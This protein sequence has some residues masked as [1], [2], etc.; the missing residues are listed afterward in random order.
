MIGAAAVHGPSAY[1]YLTR[2][3]GIVALILLSAVVV[4]GVLSSIRASGGPGLPRFAIGALHRDISLL[5]V[6][7]IVIHVVTTVLDGFAPIT[8][9]DAVIPF[10]SAYRPLWLGLGA[11]AFDL[12]LALVVTSLLRRRIGLGAWRAV[13]WFA[14]VSWPVAVLHGLGTGSDSGSV[15]A[16]AIVGACVAAVVAAV[17][18][19]I[20]QGERI[21]ARGRSAA[22]TAAVITPLAIA[23]FAVLGPLAPG[24]AARAGTPAPLLPHTTV[25]LPVPLPAAGPTAQRVRLKLPLKASLTGTVRES[26]VPGGAFIDLLMTVSG[27]ASGELRVRLAGEPSGGGLSMTGSQVDLSV[28]GETVALVGR[29]TQLQGETFTALLRAIGQRS[30]ELN[31]HLQI[32]NQTGS[33]TGTLTAGDA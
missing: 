11:L 4:L 15:W 28:R 1:W 12:V 24:W 32:D 13:H 29:I 20:A 26:R 25:A 19:R 2:G 23:L 27:G 10:I 3:S 21:P 30:I 6:V 33:V 18:V 8:L 22:I 5:A 31:V 14:Y 17:L 9:V 16:L 7:L